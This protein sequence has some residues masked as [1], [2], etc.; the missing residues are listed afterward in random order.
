MRQNPILEQAIPTLEMFLNQHEKIKD[1]NLNWLKCIYLKILKYI[2]P[3]F[4][5]TA[6][7]S[8]QRQ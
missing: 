4:F 6:V 1:R 5:F 3:S 8:P 7:F 2:L